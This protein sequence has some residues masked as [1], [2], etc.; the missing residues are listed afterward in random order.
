MKTLKG[1]AIAAAL[2]DALLLIWLWV[3]TGAS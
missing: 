2:V 3:R 1:I